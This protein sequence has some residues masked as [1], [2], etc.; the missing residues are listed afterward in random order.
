L[1]VAAAKASGC[2]YLLAEDL[3]TGQVMDGVEIVN[4]F[5]HGPE[6]F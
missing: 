5:L 1:I 2:R 3:Q 6:S 4:P